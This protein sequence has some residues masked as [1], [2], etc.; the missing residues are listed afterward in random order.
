MSFAQ[1][2]NEAHSIISSVQIHKTDGNSGESSSPVR[3]GAEHPGTAHEPPIAELVPR[4]T[5]IHTRTDGLE[6]KYA[7]TGSGGA[8]PHGDSSGGHKP[9][10]SG[11]LGKKPLRGA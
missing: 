5:K 9:Y 7:S 1:S 6:R 4:R 3:D 8:G 2:F 10:S 11:E